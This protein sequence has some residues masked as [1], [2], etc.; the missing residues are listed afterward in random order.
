MRNVFPNKYYSDEG[1]VERKLEINEE[2]LQEIIE[3]YLLRNADFDFD[4]VEIVNNRPMN[5][6]LYAKCRKY[7]DSEDP[8]QDE[9][10]QDAEVEISGDYDGNL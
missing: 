8:E 9:V 5:I 4:E 3:D 1:F 10:L 2:D 7:V 6:W